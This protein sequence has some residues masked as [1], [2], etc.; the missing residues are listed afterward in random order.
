MKDNKTP[1]NS[2]IFILDEWLEVFM[3]FYKM[4]ALTTSTLIFTF[5]FMLILD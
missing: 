5:N 3:T 2:G 4:S 1:A